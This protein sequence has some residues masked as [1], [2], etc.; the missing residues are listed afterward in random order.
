MVDLKGFVCLDLLK[1]LVLNMRKTAGS[2][3]T[4]HNLCLLA[5]A[6]VVSAEA[7]VVCVDCDNFGPAALRSY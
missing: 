5:I 6:D 1:L 3:A 7:P 4:V 2:G